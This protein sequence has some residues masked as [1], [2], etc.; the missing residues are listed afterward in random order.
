MCH[1]LKL[2][3]FISL[4]QLMAR[5]SGAY[6]NF[7]ACVCVGPVCLYVHSLQLYGCLPVCTPF[8]LIRCISLYKIGFGSICTIHHEHETIV[9][10][11]HWDLF[12]QQPIYSE[13][14]VSLIGLTCIIVAE[15]FTLD[16]N[17][18]CTHCQ[19]I[20]KRCITSLNLILRPRVYIHNQN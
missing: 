10:A 13:R 9:T 17:H 8:S 1:L 15:L 4:T 7:L 11:S 3:H 6:I 19:Y 12:I 5:Y 2:V 14:H 20:H 16:H 18:T